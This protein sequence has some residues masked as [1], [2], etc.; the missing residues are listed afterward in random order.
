MF[1]YSTATRFALALVPSLI[2]A[3]STTITFTFGDIVT[4]AVVQ[5]PEALTATV[6]VGPP[7]IITTTIVLTAPANQITEI[8]GKIPQ[9]VQDTFSEEVGNV[10]PI[11]INGYV[12][13]IR[14]P[15]SLSIP[16][17]ATLPPFTPVVIPA[18]TISAQ[19]A[20]SEVAA[21]RETVRSVASGKKR[22]SLQPPKSLVLIRVRKYSYQCFRKLRRVTSC[23]RSFSCRIHCRRCGV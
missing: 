23:F 19:S 7:R 8:A 2:V 20:A 15:A 21:A 9:S 11:N 16:A 22:K 18:A 1:S 6:T 4:T 14:L 17:D 12:T 5:L 3:Q 10:V 13:S